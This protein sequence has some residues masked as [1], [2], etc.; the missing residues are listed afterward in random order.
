MY[1][2]KINQSINQSFFDSKPKTGKWEV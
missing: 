1:L 2:I